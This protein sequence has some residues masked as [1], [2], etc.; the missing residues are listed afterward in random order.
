[1]VRIIPTDLLM[2]PLPT[3]QRKCK[4]QQKATAEAKAAAEKKAA[5]LAESLRQLE[6]ALNEA[7]EEL[8]KI[9]NRV[10]VS[11]TG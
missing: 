6:A 11:F 4:R 9:K 7:A 5:E 1:M 2:R 8:E 3:E 10:S